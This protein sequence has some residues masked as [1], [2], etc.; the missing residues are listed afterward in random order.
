MFSSLGIS[1]HSDEFICFCYKNKQKHSQDHALN[2][3]R[4]VS[5][6]KYWGWIYKSVITNVVHCYTINTS[7]KNVKIDIILN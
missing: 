2:Y 7:G 5:D 6:H 4:L 1:T 3:S